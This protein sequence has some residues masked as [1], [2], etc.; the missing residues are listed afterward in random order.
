MSMSAAASKPAAGPLL[1]LALPLRLQL[2][3]ETKLGATCCALESTEGAWFL[4]SSHMLFLLLILSLL[5]LALL[6]RLQVCFVTE[7][8][9]AC[10]CVLKSTEEDWMFSSSHT[11]SPLLLLLLL[12][13]LP[14]ASSPAGG[15]LP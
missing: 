8:G 13:V 2:C 9:A 1:A 3:F 11:L 7:L 4:S 12:L 10:R 15:L 14:P 6:L 5:A